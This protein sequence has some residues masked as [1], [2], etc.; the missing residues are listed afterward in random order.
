MPHLERLAAI[1]SSVARRVA[2]DAPLAAVTRSRACN[3][4]VD[5]PGRSVTKRHAGRVRSNT[6]QEIE[7][8]GPAERFDAVRS[9][10]IVLAWWQAADLESPCLIGRRLPDVAHGIAPF[11]LVAGED[12]DGA[13]RRR[14][15]VSVGDVADDQ[16]RLE[17]A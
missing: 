14:R 3:L 1:V 11:P 5:G 12:H 10:H 4:N 7:V 2:T 15:V 8:V 9:G 17:P 13:F 16:T 6:L